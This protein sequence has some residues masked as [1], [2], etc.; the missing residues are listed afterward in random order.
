LAPRDYIIR[1]AAPDSNNNARL[2]LLSRELPEASKS[3]RGG[4]QLAIND[5]GAMQCDI[6]GEF[7]GVWD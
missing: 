4:F 5:G 2:S 6:V 1:N 7:G 3:V